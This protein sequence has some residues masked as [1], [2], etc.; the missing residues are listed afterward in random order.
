MAT[1]TQE[2]KE[3]N[4][5]V[6][7]RTRLAGAAVLAWRLAVRTTKDSEVYTL[8]EKIA[9]DA[10]RARDAETPDDILRAMGDVV[11]GAR[12]LTK[13]PGFAE[14]QVVNGLTLIL[15]DAMVAGFAGVEDLV[16]SKKRGAR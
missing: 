14:D 15:I 1:I 9:R 7:L 8:A 10:E 11:T 3:L 12:G 6:G 13:T 16:G 2:Q 5:E 4:V